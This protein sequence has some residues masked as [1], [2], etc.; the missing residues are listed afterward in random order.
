MR[1]KNLLVAGRPGCGKT[2][3]VGSVAREFAGRVGGFLTSEIRE[4]GVRQGFGIATLDGR[5]GV[6]AHV[7]FNKAIRVGKYGVDVHA[8]ESVAV[9]AVRD[10]V[11]NKSLVLIDE[12]GRMELASDAFRQSVLR[13]LDS[14]RIVLATMLQ[15]THPFTDAL[16]RRPDVKVF[17]ITHQNRNSILETIVMIVE[18][19]LSAG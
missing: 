14:D 17:E 4:R 16:K 18:E 12:I 2:T 7:N 9:P 6:L 13:A 8:L 3:L 5:T 10:A 15:H 11:A 1:V 19:L